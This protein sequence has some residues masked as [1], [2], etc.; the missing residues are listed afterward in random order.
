M[1]RK[2]LEKNN[3][4]KVVTSEKQLKRRTREMERWGGGGG[5]GQTTSD[6]VPSTVLLRPSATNMHHWYTHSSIQ[7]VFAQCQQT[8]LKH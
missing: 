6:L 7:Q 4:P 3:K 1:H 2:G 8:S 5:K